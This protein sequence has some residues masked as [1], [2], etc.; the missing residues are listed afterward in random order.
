MPTSSVL[1]QIP[2]FLHVEQASLCIGSQIVRTP[3]LESRALNT[4]TGMRILVKPEGLQ[5]TGSFKI[6]GAINRIASL[7]A[8]EKRRG[9]VARSSGNHGQA[10]AFAG[11]A[12]GVSVIVV[13]P[14]SSPAIKIKLIKDLGARV[15]QV[16][17]SELPR[18]ATQ[19][20]Q[21]EGRT[22]VPPADD[23]HVV[24]GAGTVAKEV[25]EQAA[26]MGVHIDALFA[27]CSGGGLTA[28]C[29]LS[30]DALSPETQ[31]VAVE[32]EGFEKMARSMKAGRQLDLEPGGSSIC[33][34]I[35]G[36]FTAR[37]PFEILRQSNICLSSVSD[38]SAMEAMRTAAGDF[39]LIVEPG[40][41]VSLAAA[42]KYGETFMGKT[43]AV[44]L[45]GR[46][47]DTALLQRALT[48]GH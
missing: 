5:P 40:G 11:A 21:D 41:A 35:N 47:V 33:D 26:E 6:R 48:E 18:T 45:T 34:A 43:V 29:L 30:R 28:G 9:V 25:F 44:I 8:E 27:C 17:M 31:L 12:A 22:L 14:T 38:R 7:S 3:L 42:M 24:A 13:A 23:F 16:P 19:I 37:I 4:L 10:M 36:L 46:N 1:P 39:G 15:V 2:D 20:Q 32:A